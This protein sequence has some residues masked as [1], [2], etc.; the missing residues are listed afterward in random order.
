[1]MNEIEERKKE[2]DEKELEWKLQSL[3]RSL[4]GVT[5]KRKR[6]EIVLDIESTALELG[7][8]KI[9]KNASFEEHIIYQNT[10][11]PPLPSKELH[12]SNLE[13]F[14]LNEENTEKTEHGLHKKLEFLHTKTIH[15]IDIDGD[16]NSNLTST[17]SPSP[18]SSS[19][20][21][22]RP[23][24]PPTTQHSNW[25]IDRLYDVNGFFVYQHQQQS[26]PLRRFLPSSSSLRYSPE[27][28]AL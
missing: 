7:K 3:R 14:A 2:K 24:I 18:S 4:F 12:A 13:L 9:A 6:R 27:P 15:K 26:L 19:S 28:R 21:S 5:S 16:S 8:L 10:F 25:W 17:S 11:D 23:F 20:S 22:S 1:M